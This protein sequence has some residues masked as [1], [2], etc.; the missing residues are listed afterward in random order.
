MPFP[1][2]CPDCPRLAAPARGNLGTT[3]LSRLR[4]LP[5]TA[6]SEADNDSEVRCSEVWLSGVARR[7]HCTRAGKGNSPN[8]GQ[9]RRAISRELDGRGFLPR[10]EGAYASVGLVLALERVLAEDDHVVAVGVEVAQDARDRVALA[11]VEPPRRLVGRQR[12]GFDEQ[13]AAVPPAD[14]VLGVAAGSRRPT[15][16]AV[17]R[18][19]RRRSSRCTTSRRSSRPGRSRR[20]RPAG[21]RV[22][23]RR[24]CDARPC[25]RR[26]SRRGVRQHVDLVGLE[27]A[28]RGGELDQG[29]RVGRGWRDGSSASP[30][31]GRGANRWDIAGER[32]ASNGRTTNL[33]DPISHVYL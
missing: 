21:P 31:V 27:D 18:R 33:D 14:V 12:R 13:D 22:R 4:P 7:H 9:F 1:C 25:R 10:P 23:R 28:R 24:R 3:T 8:Q 16:L 32:V 15:P 5:G 26:G 2:P 11:Q 6:G 29:G 30:R 17:E 20:S 19:A